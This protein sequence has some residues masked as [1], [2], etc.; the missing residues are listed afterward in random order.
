MSL[1]KPMLLIDEPIDRPVVVEISD[2]SEDSDD[3]NVHD[4][5]TKSDSISTPKNNQHDASVNKIDS[6]CTEDDSMR[7]SNGSLN[8][9]ESELCQ[10]IENVLKQDNVHQQMV[11]THSIL[12][13]RVHNMMKDCLQMK[14]KLTTLQKKT[15]KWDAELY[16]RSKFRVRHK[17]PLDIPASNYISSSNLYEQENMEQ[18]VGISCT[19]HRPFIVLNNV[20]VI[21]VNFRNYQPLA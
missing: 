12:N 15:R 18:L 7:I 8:V 9:I 16:S 4:G 5:S 11:F 14:Q 21:I 20:F 10:I 1:N 2:S 19:S 6:N 3:D 13:A 17:K